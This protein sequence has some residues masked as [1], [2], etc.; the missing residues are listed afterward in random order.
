[1]EVYSSLIPGEVRQDYSNS[2]L[3]EADDGGHDPGTG[4]KN[5]SSEH[6]NAMK[7]PVAASL[8]NSTRPIAQLAVSERCRMPV[9]VSISEAAN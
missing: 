4:V 1:V 7:E 6:E 5:R 9:G 3:Q 2:R 8:A